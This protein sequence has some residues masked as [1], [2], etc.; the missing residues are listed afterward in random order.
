MKNTKYILNP[1]YTLQEDFNRI[2]LVHDDDRHYFFRYIHPMHAMMLSFFKGDKS[3]EENIIEIISYF[4]IDYDFASNL[5]SKFLN[6]N[7]EIHILYD[8]EVFDFPEKM[9]VVNEDSLYRED[10][11]IED[12]AIEP[13]YDFKT[14]RCNKPK[15]IVF[16]VNTT[17][18]TD[19]I[20]CYANKNH[21]FNPLS[22]NRILSIIDEAK[23]LGVKNFDISG[24]ELFLQ[25]DWDIILKH[26]LDAGY[27]P[28][29]STKVPLTNKSVSI[30]KSLG[31]KQLQISV[32]TMDERLVTKDLN[33]GENYI[34]RM[35]SS[36]KLLDEAGFELI[37]KGTQTKDTLTVENIQ[38]VFDFISTLKH[39]KR[40]MISTIGYMHYKPKELF[41]KLHPTLEQ[42]E[43]VREFVNE[44]AKITYFEM[45][46]DDQSLLKKQMCNQKEF[47]DRSLCSANV[48]GIVILPD[49]KVTICEELY[50]K[51]QFVIGDLNSD[52][53]INVWKS[54]KA[55]DLWNLQQSIIPQKSACSS[56]KEFDECRHHLGVCW[57][58]VIGAYGNENYLFPDPRCPQAPTIINNICYD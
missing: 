31:I 26:L 2:I 15:E 4:D 11:N 42:I 5:I 48:N 24:G 21:T 19:C 30:L 44:K 34:E 16:V 7:K 29:I 41:S 33:V 50:W 10:L 17:C 53:L 55:L 52:S 37:I 3:L 28:Y 36:L 1:I 22:T 13:P 46:L 56:C 40:Y 39:V 49:G 18:A 9:L 20:Y 25:K 57:K 35:K 54:Q 38:G 45:Y 43:V 6:N 32:D 23:N 47:K 51:P 12:F 14:L 27:E 8:N 58:M